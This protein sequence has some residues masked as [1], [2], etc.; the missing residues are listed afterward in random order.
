MLPSGI[1]NKIAQTVELFSRILQC[2]CYVVNCALQ[3]GRHAAGSKFTQAAP[4]FLP[5]YD[6]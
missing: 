1:L 3:V 4:L 2:A 6:L 5:S